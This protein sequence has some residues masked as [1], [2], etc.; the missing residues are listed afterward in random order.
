M[1]R[2]VLAAA[3]AEA[4]F[5]SHLS[6][7]VTPT[8]PEVNAAIADA[9]RRHG[10]TLGC[11]ARMAAEYGDHP[12]TAPARM[13]WA[14]VVVA[15]LYPSGHGAESARVRLLIRRDERGVPPQPVGYLRTAA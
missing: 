8:L 13:R 5:N 6:Q 12:E 15:A 3:R 14:T 9:L 1:T 11:A 10:G 7:S 4:L 2:D